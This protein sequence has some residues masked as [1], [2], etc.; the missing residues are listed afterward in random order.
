MGTTKDSQKHQVFPSGAKRN[1]Q[2]G[3]GRFD[4]ISPFI[5]LSLAFR[6]EDG[7]EIYGPRNWEKGMPLSRFASAAFRH[8]IQAVYGM[9]DEDHWG[10]IIFNI[11]CLK[12]GKEMIESGEWP[13][14]LDDLPNYSKEL[15]RIWNERDKQL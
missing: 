6:L 2:Q 4:L 8:L 10:G 3:K 15:E 13:E 11:M 14:E 5:F 7:A 9:D 1:S 12:H